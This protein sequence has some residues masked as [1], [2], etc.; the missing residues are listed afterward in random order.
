MDLRY[1]GNPQLLVAIEETSPD[2]SPEASP[3]PTSPSPESAQAS[4]ET[5]PDSS[6]SS[7]ESPSLFDLDGSLSRTFRVS[8]LHM[9]VGTSEQSLARWPTSGMAWL[10]GLSTAASSEC[11]SDEDGCSSSE[12]MLTEILEPPQNVPETYL[13]STRAAAGILARATKR[14]KTLP[15][16][17]KVALISLAGSPEPSGPSPTEDSGQLTLT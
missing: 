11:R 10:G 16:F 12:P 14:G 5:S 9:A 13:L 15:P 8:S 7:L 17:L 3:A 6:S 2:S 1:P 4:P